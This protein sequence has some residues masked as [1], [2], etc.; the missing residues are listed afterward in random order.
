MD[1]KTKY[2]YKLPLWNADQLEESL[3]AVHQ[4]AIQNAETQI[5]WYSE[6]KS[7][8]RL[9]SQIIRACTIGFAALGAL[10]PLL[11]AAEMLPLLAEC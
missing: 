9:G 11:D 2:E 4:W 3:Q 5:G 7:S 8:K 6:N 10:C 1:D